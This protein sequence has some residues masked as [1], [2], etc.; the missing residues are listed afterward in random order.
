MIPDADDKD[1]GDRSQGL[2]DMLDLGVVVE[3]EQSI[4]LRPVSAEAAPEFG[5]ADAGCAH[6]LIEPDLGNGQRRQAR[7]FASA[8]R[9][10]RRDVLTPRHRPG[11]GLLDRIAGAPQ[12]ILFILAECG[13]LGQVG[14]SDEQR[15]VV[16]GF[17]DKGYSTLHSSIQAKILLDLANQPAPKLPFAPVYRK[18]GTAIAA[19][20]G[21]V[22]AAAFM[23][24]ETAAVPRQPSRAFTRPK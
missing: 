6:G 3:I 14:A 8:Q 22:T 4:D 2:V 20:H 13:H 11:Q 7:R 15:L 17:Y 9:W 18:L 10:G 12:R 5:F 23:G 16:V 21:E 19:D 24:L 1:L